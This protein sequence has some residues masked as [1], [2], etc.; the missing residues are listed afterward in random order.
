MLTESDAIAPY[1]TEP[2][3]LYHG[4]A[5]CV[6]KRRTTEKVAQVLAVCNES[7]IRVTPQDANTGLA[8]GQTP[9]TSGA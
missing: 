3:R 4:R 5:L 7:G 1:V 9:D 8:G 2:R 6:V